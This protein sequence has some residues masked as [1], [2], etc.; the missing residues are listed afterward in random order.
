VL[1]FR[2]WFAL[3]DEALEEKVSADRGGVARSSDEVV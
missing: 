1:R 2:S 3:G